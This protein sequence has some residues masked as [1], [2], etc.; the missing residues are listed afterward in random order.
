MEVAK[1]ICEKAPLYGI[2]DEP[3]EWLYHGNIPE[4]PHNIVEYKYGYNVSPYIML[5]RDYGGAVV[6]EYLK[7]NALDSSRERC[8]RTP[9]G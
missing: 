2:K 4:F 1:F 9:M 6:M 5:K 7:Y 8:Q 3:W